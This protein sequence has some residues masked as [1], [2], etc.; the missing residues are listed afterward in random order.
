MCLA[1]CLQDGGVTGAREP[2][3]LLPEGSHD[4]GTW[5]IRLDRDMEERV[6]SRLDS[7]RA[8]VSPR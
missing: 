5:G 2:A 3:S 4:D 8:A 7:F 6:K 1:A